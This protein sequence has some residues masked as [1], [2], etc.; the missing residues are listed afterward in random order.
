MKRRHRLTW[1]LLAAVVLVAGLRAQPLS[2]DTFRH[3]AD[4]LRPSEAECTFQEI[5]WRLSFPDGIRDSQTLGKPLLLW[6]MNGHP[7]GCT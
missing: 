6:A 1:S 4:Y 3:W 5:D 7:M 2:D